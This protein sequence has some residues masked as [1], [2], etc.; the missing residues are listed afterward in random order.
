MSLYWCADACSVNCRVNTSQEVGLSV[1]QLG[2]LYMHLGWRSGVVVSA[3]ASINEVNQRRARLVLCPGSI[4]GAGHLFR[5]VTNQPPKANSAVHPS[6]AA[7]NGR[8]RTSLLKLA[9]YDR[10]NTPRIDMF[11]HGIFL[12]SAS[13]RRRRKMQGVDAGMQGIDDRMHAASV[14]W[15]RL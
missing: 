3:L 12:R 6:G 1:A 14:V 8:V 5:Y 4:P 2:W 9:K 15:Q 13:R 10:K 7:W 11:I